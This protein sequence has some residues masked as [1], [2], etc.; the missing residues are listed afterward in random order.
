MGGGEGLNQLFRQPAGE[1]DHG[2]CLGDEVVRLSSPGRA[3]GSE[4]LA[5]LVS[6]PEG[7]VSGC[8]NRS[9]ARGMANVR[10]WVVYSSRESTSRGLG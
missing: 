4:I 1:A 5:G 8:R 2:A 3:H 6:A 10:G 9:L 7:D